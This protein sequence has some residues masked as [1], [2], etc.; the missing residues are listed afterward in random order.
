MNRDIR[1]RRKH[2]ARLVFHNID[3]LSTAR[4]G[5]KLNSAFTHAPTASA[6]VWD[7]FDDSPLVWDT[8]KKKPLQ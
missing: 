5:M 4:R 1:E 3:D 2:F 6:H 7:I 8:Q